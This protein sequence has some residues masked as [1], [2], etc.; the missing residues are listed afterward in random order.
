MLFRSREHQCRRS[1]GG[2]LFSKKETT[3]ERMLIV[4]FVARVQRDAIRENVAIDARAHP[5]E[6]KVAG[7]IGP[8]QDRTIKGEHRDSAQLLHA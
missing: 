6:N 1:D 5:V 2:M 8:K 4:E 7:I 3:A